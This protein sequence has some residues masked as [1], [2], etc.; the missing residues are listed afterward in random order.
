M[1]SFGFDSQT[2]EIPQW[3]M[4]GVRHLQPISRRIRLPRRIPPLETSAALAQSAERLTRN[5]KVWGSIPQGGST[6]SQDVTSLRSNFST[7]KAT[8][9]TNRANA[10]APPRA[11]FD[12]SIDGLSASVHAWA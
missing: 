9:S 8:N 4:T 7:A 12:Q 10:Y 2:T 11:M 1:H 3:Q 5:E 6:Q